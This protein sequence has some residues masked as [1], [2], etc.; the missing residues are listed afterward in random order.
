[1]FRNRIGRTRAD[2]L[3]E[4]KLNY[5]LSSADSR[6]IIP[7]FNILRSNSAACAS[8][9]FFVSNP[10]VNRPKQLAVV[11]HRMT[12]FCF[13]RLDLPVFEIALV[14]E[15]LDHISSWIVNADH[16]HECNVICGGVNV[17]DAFRQVEGLVMVSD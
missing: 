3:P 8:N 6:R 4:S 5:Q 11:L 9:L 15:R 16:L 10:P 14:L 12:A 2:S 7:K 17:G 1:M 13:T